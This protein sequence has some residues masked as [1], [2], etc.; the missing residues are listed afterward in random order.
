M[1][2]KFKQQLYDIIFE[3]DTKSGEIFDITLLLFILLSII[4]VMLESVGAIEQKYG[5]LLRISEWIITII[6]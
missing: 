1:T 6:F 3:A 2:K 5:N 4:A